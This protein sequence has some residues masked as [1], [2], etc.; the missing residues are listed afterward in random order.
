MSA[1]AVETLDL[2]NLLPEEEQ[3][4]ALN[5]VRQVVNAWCERNHMPNAETIEALKEAEEME[6]HPERYK[7]Y[8]SFREFMDEAENEA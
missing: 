3:Q 8:S 7:R 6:K 5:L 2:L 1:I 4:L